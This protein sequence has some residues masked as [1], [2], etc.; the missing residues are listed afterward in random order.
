LST[1]G[2][3]VAR[4]PERKHGAVSFKS[5]EWQPKCHHNIG[6]RLLC[7]DQL[8]RTLP[9]RS[10]SVKIVAHLER[11]APAPPSRIAAEE[12]HSFAPVLPSMNGRKVRAQSLRRP[13]GK[14]YA[15]AGTF[16]MTSITLSRVRFT[17]LEL[18]GSLSPLKVALITVT[19][20]SWATA[21][22]LD[23]MEK[24]GNETVTIKRELF[25]DNPHKHQG[26]L[27]MRLRMEGWA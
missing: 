9:E 6:K 24:F 4:N 12:C 21:D 26:R 20:D 5:A 22:Q 15:E 19:S 1:V 27:G 17:L 16:F 13:I 11:V 10:K 25:L 2:S 7:H 23:R 14:S 18:I 8:I 3:L